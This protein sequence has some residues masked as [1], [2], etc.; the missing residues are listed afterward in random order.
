MQ[1]AGG[2]ISRFTRVATGQ[3]S[4]FPLPLLKR[5]QGLNQRAGAALLNLLAHQQM[6]ISRGGYHRLVGNTK[7]L[8]V[9]GLSLIH[10]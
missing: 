3:F 7:H 5:A 6:L 8:A 4:Q 2:K 9:L 1:E 10:I